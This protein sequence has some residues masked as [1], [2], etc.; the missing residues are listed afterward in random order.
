MTTKKKYVAHSGIMD[1]V[2]SLL[3]QDIKK[4]EQ[5]PATQSIMTTLA[6]KMRADIVKRTAK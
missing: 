1:S 2:G 6:A 4:I 3:M 5:H